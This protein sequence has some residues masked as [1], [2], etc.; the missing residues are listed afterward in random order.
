MKETVEIMNVPFDTTGMSGAVNK[1]MGFFEDGGEHIVCT[2]NPEIVM[3]AQKDKVLFGILKAADLVVPDGVGIVWASKFSKNVLKE[4]VSGY[5]LCLKLFE[6]MKESNKTVYLFGGA[7]G[8]AAEAAKR[9]SL[10]YKGINVVGYRN[11]YFSAKDERK[12]I[13]DIKDVSPDLLLVGLG[14]PKQ[15]KWIYDNLRFT[16]AKTAIGVGGSFD[17]MAGNVKRAPAFY[18][19]FGIEWLYRLIKQPSRFKR[20]LKLPEFAMLI[21]IKRNVK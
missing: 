11:G 7:P 4:R 12:I 16:G 19:K 20:M 6:K 21:L 5:D 17:V 13:A 14:S 18:R 8:V 10:K 1:I 9:I 2:P 15:E 3:E